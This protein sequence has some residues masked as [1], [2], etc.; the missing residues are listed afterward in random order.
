M[1]DTMMY[2]LAYDDHADGNT[3]L[4]EEHLVELGYTFTV[5]LDLLTRHDN[6]LIVNTEAYEDNNHDYFAL[7]PYSIT[8][9]LGVYA[10]PTK[11]VTNIEYE[12]IPS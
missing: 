6:V 3:Y 8:M 5:A 2:I 11:G 12:T 7:A 1:I 9:G 10:K 4:A